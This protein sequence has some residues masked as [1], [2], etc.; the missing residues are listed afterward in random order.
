MSILENVSQ[1]DIRYKLAPHITLGDLKGSLV[2]FKGQ[3]ITKIDG[4]G[5]VDF[6]EEIFEY[7]VRKNGTSIRELD[8][9]FV[10]K[11]DRIKEVFQFVLE[12]NLCINTATDFNFPSFIIYDRT[13]RQAKMKD[14]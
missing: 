4:E 11:K 9:K 2:A 14:I 12:N 13:G 8:K 7:I 10:I 3:Y 1:E 6:I 5:I